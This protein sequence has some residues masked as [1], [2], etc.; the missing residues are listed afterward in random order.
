M[1]VCRNRLQGPLQIEGRVVLVIVSPCRPTPAGRRRSPSF[2]ASPHSHSARTGKKIS[3]RDINTDVKKKKKTEE[4]VGR[5]F[6][7]MR[8]APTCI[9]TE[10]GVPAQIR[11]NKFCEFS[12]IFG[13]NTSP[14]IPLTSHTDRRVS[15]GTK[16]KKK[17]NTDPSS[18][19]RSQTYI[20]D[21][22]PVEITL[23]KLFFMIVWI[24]SII[25]CEIVESRK[26]VSLL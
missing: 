24:R 16:D 14:P 20:R 19:I 23:E 22:S 10:L 5:E 2:P 4:K 6:N 26:I 8:D 3:N 1:A 17:K 11:T 13:K 7:L 25:T 12:H 18:L 15:R 21:I 9:C